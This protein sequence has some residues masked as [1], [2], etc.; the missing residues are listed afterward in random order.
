M[1]LGGRCS[2]ASDLLTALPQND[3]VSDSI[4]AS[5]DDLD[6]HAMSQALPATS[7]E[8]PAPPSMLEQNDLAPPLD[9]ISDCS[10]SRSGSPQ[11]AGSDDDFNPGGIFDTPPDT[12]PES[13]DEEG[14]P[15]LLEI[16]HDPQFE[17]SEA[18]FDM[19]LD[20]G[21]DNL[22]PGT[23]SP[24]AFDEDPLIWN[25]YITAFLLATCQGCTQETI[26]RYLDSMYVTFV[27]FQNRT[28][29]EMRGLDT[30]V[31]TLQSVER[32]LRIDPNQ[33]IIYYFLCTVCWARHHPS[34][35]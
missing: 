1:R 27:G 9:N 7:L 18:I 16:N 23:S 33:Y 19:I 15:E 30:M 20:T 31:R 29:L 34:T 35:L 12:P 28:H 4:H 32:R 8:A 2:L 17:T 11:N 22:A 3:P 26:K 21:S 10:M 25:T 14:P 13:D 24:P 6:V 5:G